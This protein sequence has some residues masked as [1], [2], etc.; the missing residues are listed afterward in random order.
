MFMRLGKLPYPYHSFRLLML[1]MLPVARTFLNYV[2]HVRTIGPHQTDTSTHMYSV[3]ILAFTT[4]LYTRFPF[5]SISPCKPFGINH[6]VPKLLRYTI[7]HNTCQFAYYKSAQAQQ[8]VIAHNVQM[9]W[10][11]GSGYYKKGACT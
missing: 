11:T 1:R 5:Y 10:A 6:N 8:Q 2:I 4:T 9:E 7:T 3:K